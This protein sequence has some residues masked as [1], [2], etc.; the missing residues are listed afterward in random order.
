MSQ[1]FKYN[2]FE[3]YGIEIEYMIV[4]R[5]TLL[6]EPIAHLLLTD[7][8]GAVQNSIKLGDITISNE[9]AAHVIELKT[10]VPTSNLEASSQNFHDTI[11]S[12]NKKLAPHEAIILPGGMHPF[13]LPKKHSGIWEYGEKEIYQWYNR[14]FDCRSHGWLNLQS[15]H[16]N[17]P[18]KNESEFTLLHDAVIV[19][20]PLL[21]ALSAASPYLEGRNHKHLDTRLIV[22]AE[23]QK[24]RP[25]I[26]GQ[27][28]PERI[29]NQDSY[30][31]EILLPAY[32]S[33]KSQDP[34]GIVES[35]WLNSRGAIARFDRG[36]VE[37][38]ILDTQ[39]NPNSDIAICFLTIELLKR[40]TSLGS[41]ALKKLALA[42]SPAQRKKHLLSCARDGRQARL[43]DSD[44]AAAILG[45]S[46]GVP[47]NLGEFWNSF[48]QSIPFESVP[49]TLRNPIET[50]VRKGNLA[51]RVLRVYGQK[52][53]KMEMMHLVNELA[54]CVE[55]NASFQTPSLAP[56]GQD[57]KL[58]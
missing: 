53:S 15:C 11:K 49:E 4:N 31:R 5:K 13:M 44:A 37:I 9:L 26:A 6:P 33:I 51:E 52:P 57:T 43:R 23:N 34:D 2:L 41:A 29:T 50:L 28:I 10:S 54:D 24:K 35:D 25:L 39:E 20:L 1:S 19:A 3:A 42:F 27:I 55:T 58:N 38:R 21:P 46:N 47:K 12:I 45:E 40:L 8:K 17:L 32:E 30:T 16:I 22:Y 36:S 7:S 48:Y 56:S 14:V 18:F